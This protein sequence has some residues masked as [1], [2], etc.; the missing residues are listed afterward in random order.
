MFVISVFLKNALC[1][2]VDTIFTTTI[3]QTVFNSYWL[4][5]INLYVKYGNRLN[6]VSQQ[7]YCHVFK[8]KLKR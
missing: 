1:T 8:E 2:Y 6:F 5:S 4:T 3:K 7:V